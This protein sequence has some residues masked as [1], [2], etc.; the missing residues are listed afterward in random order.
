MEFSEYIE[1]LKRKKQTILSVL[2][3]FVLVALILSFVQPFEYEAK[4]KILV[5]QS[6]APGMDPFQVS[7]S[8]AYITKVLA[9]IINT[10]SFYQEVLNAGFN[11]NKNYFTDDPKKQIK[12]WNHTVYAGYMNDSGMINIS[13]FH[14]DK[15]Q[16]D[17]I[18]RAINQTIKAKHAQYHGAGDSVKIS[19]IELPLVSDS[20]V[21]P[22]IAYN[23]LLAASLGLI[24]ALSFIYLFPGEEYDLSLLP[25][26]RR[27]QNRKTKKEEDYV[28]DYLDR[29][30]AVR[31]AIQ[32]LKKAPSNPAKAEAVA[33]MN[34]DHIYTKETEFK[35]P[36]QTEAAQED[37]DELDYNDVINSGKMENLLN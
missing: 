7:K 30:K 21:K 12:I 26:H 20:P 16:A 25:F 18:I 14:K 9:K 17:Q 11:I 33:S 34:T 6:Y 35:P 3:L 31:E 24:T 10:N 15:Y 5:V 29:E 2:V 8:N 4:S 13:V 19:V 27:R 1:V 37:K 23:L 22:S 28:S 36:Y 32:R